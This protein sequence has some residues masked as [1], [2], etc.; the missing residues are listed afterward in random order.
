MF[1]G[2]ASGN[3]VVAIPPEPLAGG[4]D[5]LAIT[6]E[7]GKAENPQPKGGGLVIAGAAPGGWRSRRRRAAGGT[8]ADYRATRGVASSVGLA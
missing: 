2:D 5:Q 1:E 7:P 6:Q 8:A 3:V 4:A